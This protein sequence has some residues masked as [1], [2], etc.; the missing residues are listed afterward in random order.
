MI[1]SNWSE[2]TIP[3]YLLKQQGW[4]TPAAF[5]PRTLINVNFQTLFGDGN[6]FSFSVDAISFY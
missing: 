1:D 5:D 4:G 6:S 2:Q 3:F